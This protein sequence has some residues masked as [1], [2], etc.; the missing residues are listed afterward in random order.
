MTGMLC[1]APVFFV[2]LFLEEGLPFGCA[3]YG[4]CKPGATL[5]S[6]RHGTWRARA[7]SDDV[8][9]F[10]AVLGVPICVGIILSYV[11]SANRG[12]LRCCLGLFSRL[13]VDNSGIRGV[14]GFRY[15]S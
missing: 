10:A 3:G 2:C 7:V 9:V 12:C 14:A 1:K 8:L 11:E 5:C 13:V 4:F 15:C 6:M